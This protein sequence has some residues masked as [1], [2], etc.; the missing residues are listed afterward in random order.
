M[1]IG[2]LVLCWRP[3]PSSDLFSYVVVLSRYLFT[4]LFSIFV[5]AAANLFFAWLASAHISAQSLLEVRMI[6]I[7]CSSPL[8]SLRRV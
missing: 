6:Y 1:S 2:Y 5:G 3:L 7:I 4:M 8:I